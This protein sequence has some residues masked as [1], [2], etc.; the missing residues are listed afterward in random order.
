M[1][2]DHEK[3]LRLTRD[4]LAHA[5]AMAGRFRDDRNAAIRAAIRDGMSMYRV[6]QI[7]GISQQA[8]ARIRDA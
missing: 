1:S 8:V 5:E 2:K 3:A 4:N 7:I 6:A